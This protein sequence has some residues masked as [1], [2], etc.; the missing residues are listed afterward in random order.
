MPGVADDPEYEVFGAPCQLRLLLGPEHGRTIPLPDIS[1]LGP[2]IF[3]WSSRA[4]IFDKGR[5]PKN[6]KDDDQDRDQAHPQHHSGRHIGHLHHSC[7]S[8]D[9]V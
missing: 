2:N 1:M 4:E 9:S 5:N 8:M 6:H 7:L 3:P